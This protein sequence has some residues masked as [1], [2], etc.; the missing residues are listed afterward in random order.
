MSGSVYSNGDLEYQL[1]YT[2]QQ[3]KG[4]TFIVLPL[5]IRSYQ[6][7]LPPKGYTA[8][9]TQNQLGTSQR[10]TVFKVTLCGVD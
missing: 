4:V 9:K 1:D 10:L 7:V 5:E 3:G 8:F 6:P 2:A